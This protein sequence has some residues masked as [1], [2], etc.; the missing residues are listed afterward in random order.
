[1]HTSDQLQEMDSRL[2]GHFGSQ[3]WW[4]ADTTFEIMLGAILTQNTNWQNVEKAIANLKTAGL[5]SLAAM[6]ILPVVELADCTIS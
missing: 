2:H 3:D 6:S 5:L 4:P 1:M